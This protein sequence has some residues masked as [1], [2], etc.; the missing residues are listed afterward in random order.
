MARGRNDI[1]KNVLQ[2]SDNV[3]CLFVSMLCVPFNNF[4]VMSGRSHSFLGITSP[5]RRVNVSL[6]KDTARRR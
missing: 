6:L 2:K 1:L 3:N 4:S 5:F